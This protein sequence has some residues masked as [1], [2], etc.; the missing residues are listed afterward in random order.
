MDT[1]EESCQICQENNGMVLDGVCEECEPKWLEQIG[2]IS[3][4]VDANTR[5]A[6][7]F[8]QAAKAAKEDIQNSK[9][10]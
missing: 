10:S 3:K 9:N 4:Q 1:V 5:L 2:I 6:D 8:E 7:L